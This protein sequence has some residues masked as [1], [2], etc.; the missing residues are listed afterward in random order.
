MVYLEVTFSIVCRNIE[1]ILA[2]HGENVKRVTSDD[3]ALEILAE[4]DNPQKPT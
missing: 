4:I 3:E 1:E 2:A